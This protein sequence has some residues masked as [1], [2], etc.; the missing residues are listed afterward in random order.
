MSDNIEVNPSDV[1]FLQTLGESKYSVIF[2]VAIRDEVKVMKVYHDRRPSEHDSPGCEVNPFVCESSAYRRLKEKGLCKRGVV[3]DFYGTIVKIQ[4][5]LWPS[6]HMFSA[7]V[8][9][10]NAILLEYIPNMRQMDLSIFSEHRLNELNRILHDI[11]RAGVLHGDPDPRNMMVC[12]GRC[13]KQDRVLWIDFDSAQLL[14]E[15]NLSPQQK[16]S[17]RMKTS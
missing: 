12:P 13:G 2:K 11:H 1:V 6:L 10:P 4:P 15:H 17:S 9:L 16:R 5:N 14:S 7:D 8:L 3:P